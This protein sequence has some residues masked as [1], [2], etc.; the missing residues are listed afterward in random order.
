MKKRVKSFSLSLLAGLPLVG[1]LPSGPAHAAGEAVF[2]EKQ[3]AAIVEIVRDALKN[4]PSILSDAIQSIR[5][6]A[7]SQQ[8]AHVKAAVRAN[9]QALST[10]PSYAVRGNPQ[11]QVTVVEFLD[12]RCTYCRHMA[13]VV[14]QFLAKHS[15]VR[16]VEKVIP[17]LGDASIL[18]AR[19]IYAAAFQGQYDAMRRRL[20]DETGKPSM[21]HIRD[22]AKSLKLDMTR[23]DK[24]MKGQAVMGILAANLSQAQSVGV[25][26]TPTF[27]FGQAAVAPGALGMEQMEQFLEAAR[28][29]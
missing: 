8:E 7:S 9:W 1:L 19:A 5:Q 22:I 28:K 23:F 25:Q 27:L 11:G 16:L 17:V 15:D 26:G 4:D 13:P 18:D 21:E 3:R 29:G 20:M 6:Q 14:D 12:P 10:A 2:N 24:D